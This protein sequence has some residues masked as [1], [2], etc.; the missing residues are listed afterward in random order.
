MATDEGG[1]VGSC[2]AFHDLL[3]AICA[4]HEYDLAQAFHRGLTG[5]PTGEVSVNGDCQTVFSKPTVSTINKP[6]TQ[7]QRPPTPLLGV[8]PQASV[9]KH[10]TNDGKDDSSVQGSNQASPRKTRRASWAQSVA[11]TVEIV[12]DEGWS[13]SKFIRSDHFDKLSS[14]LLISNAAFLCVQVDYAFQE[15]TP[16]SIELTDYTFNSLFLIELLLRFFAFGC[17][18]FWCDKE[19]RAW[20]AFDFVIVALSTI[21]MFLSLALQGETLLGNVTVL[22]VIRVARIVRVLRMIRVLKF[23][24]DLRI[25]V[26]SIV[27][28]LKTA[29]FAFILLSVGMYM[30]AIA[31]T[32]LVADYMTHCRA[33]GKA[34]DNW[35]DM[36]FFF[37][38]VGHSVFALFMTVS[39]GVD[40]KDIALP[41]L[42]V[43]V[44]AITIYTIYVVFMILCVMNVLTGIF[45]QSAIETA[46]ND[47]ENV[48]KLQLQEKQ[49][50]INTL[51]QM[52]AS[53]D[54]SADGKCTLE[55]FASH[56]TDEAT[57]G[58]LRTLEI[59]ARDAIA[60]FELLD[61]HGTGEIDLEEFITGCITLR[62]G[63]KAVHM[64]KVV[65]TLKSIEMRLNALL[66]SEKANNSSSMRN[67]EPKLLE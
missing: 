38:S 7:T 26:A 56:L 24:Q 9:S 27:C 1:S 62:G 53:W 44:L 48:M 30:F 36:N 22:R 61:V 12:P 67:A 40:W 17:Y 63:A 29:G 34:I 18:R 31:L 32:Q 49:D 20:N 43:G 16:T 47:R 6:D 65:D 45:C 35:E 28:T 60:L 15:S 57:E 19:N 23:F 55:E 54:D 39:G 66:K 8:V 59:E 14:V 5:K 4:Q 10:G 64:E 33:D 46:Q 50:Y 3:R 41:L 13:F 42:E 2:T 25:M 58:L 11:R 51:K 21:D 52:F 37:G